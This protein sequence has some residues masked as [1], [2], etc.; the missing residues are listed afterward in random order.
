MLLLTSL[1]PHTPSFREKCMFFSGA[2]AAESGGKQSC[3][4]SSTGFWQMA[5]SLFQ[6]VAVLCESGPVHVLIQQLYIKHLLCVR[7]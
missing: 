7:C 1:L 2:R 6:I 5:T 4:P 3:Q